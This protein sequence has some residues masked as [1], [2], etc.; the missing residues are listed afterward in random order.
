M[1]C[2]FASNIR[3]VVTRRRTRQSIL[4]LSIVPLMAFSL[5]APPAVTEGAHGPATDLPGRLAQRP[6]LMGQASANAIQHIIIID[7]ENRSFDSMFGTFPGA[8][9]STT[10]HD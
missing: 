1:V 4:L 2:M 8:N 9:G 3:P 10:F 6:S 7:K 5:A